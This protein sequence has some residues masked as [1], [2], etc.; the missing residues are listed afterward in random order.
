MLMSKILR[1]PSFPL[2]VQRSTETC[3]H[4]SM[5]LSL[6]RR[7]SFMCRSFMGFLH[8]SPWV[9]EAALA[10]LDTVAVVDV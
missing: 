6:E 5:R 10:S 3:S 2:D 1:S 8:K 4:A 7:P 9:F